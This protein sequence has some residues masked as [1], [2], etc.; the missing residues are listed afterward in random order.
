[1]VN[2]AEFEQNNAGW[3]SE[4]VISFQTINLFYGNCEKYIVLWAEKTYWTICFHVYSS[5][6][7]L[8]KEFHDS[9]SL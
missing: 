1:M 4:T 3:V 8:Q 5:N 7:R 6:I 2:I 9:A